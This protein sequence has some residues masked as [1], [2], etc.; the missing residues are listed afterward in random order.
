MT[1]LLDTSAFTQSRR[2][3]NAANR[4]DELA[5]SGDLAVSS[6]IMLEILFAAQN[7]RD[8]V[9]LRKALDV[10]PHVELTQPVDAVEV[11]RRLVD[12]GQHRTPIIDVLVAATAAEHGL[13]VLHY[14]RD[15]ERL[16]EVTGGA[17]EW[18][19]P[20]GTGHQR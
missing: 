12:R 7:R 19:I 8:W 9:R 17:H 11:Q 13:T 10:L 1:H 14:D 15:F 18:V 3:L 4:V 20:A 2:N 6:I 5:Q 16:S